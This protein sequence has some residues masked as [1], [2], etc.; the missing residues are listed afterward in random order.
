MIET[1]EKILVFQFANKIPLLFDE[2]SDV[3]WKVVAQL[4]RRGYKVIPGETPLAVFVHVCSTKIP[5]KTV[6]KEFIADRHEVE[7]QILNA[8]REAV[9]NLRLQLAPR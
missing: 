1:Q 5:Y 4:D 2:A 3:S 6:G 8:I 7:H 9:R